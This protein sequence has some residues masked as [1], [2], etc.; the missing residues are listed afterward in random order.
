ME[1]FDNFV[2]ADYTKLGIFILNVKKSNNA[3]NLALLGIYKGSESPE[4][5]REN[6]GPVF[7]QLEL[8]NGSKH[9]FQ[10]RNMTCVLKL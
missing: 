5:L 10:S 9:R 6:F 4:N 7:R 1:L 3:R 8:I 2:G